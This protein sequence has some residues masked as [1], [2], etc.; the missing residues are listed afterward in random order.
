M[1]AINVAI[2]IAYVKTQQVVINVLG[3]HNNIEVYLHVTALLVIMKI[4]LKFVKVY[5]IIISFL[6]FL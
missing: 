3:N 5:Y 4:I 6:Y 2:V 1:I